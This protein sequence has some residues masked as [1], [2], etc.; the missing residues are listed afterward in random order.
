[1]LE[2]LSESDP[3]TLALADRVQQGDSSAITQMQQAFFDAKYPGLQLK[4]LAD[5]DFVRASR[6]FL[7]NDGG[8]RNLIGD[9]VG[10]W[11]GR[12]AAWLRLSGP[13]GTG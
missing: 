8:L 1:M 10:G 6:E 9:E 11:M 2:F 5:D 12:L 4:D 7:K 3:N 13:V